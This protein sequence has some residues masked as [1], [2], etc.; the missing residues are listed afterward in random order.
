MYY[1]IIFPQVRDSDP[2]DPKRERI[3]QLID[4]FKISGVNG[5]RILHCLHHMLMLVRLSSEYCFV[6]QIR[7]F[8]VCFILLR[9]YEIFFSSQ[10]SFFFQ[11]L[12]F[13]L[14]MGYLNV[15]N[16]KACKA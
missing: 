1:D 16:K 9:P 10:I 13:F 2:T 6:I 11:C 3:V 8:L 4:D 5:V 14:L 15:K 12:I 7:D